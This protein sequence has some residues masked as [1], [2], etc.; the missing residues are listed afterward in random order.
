MISHQ[1]VSFNQ[2]LSPDNTEKFTLQ[3]S[4]T[5]QGPSLSVAPTK[6]KEFISYQ[7]WTKALE[8]FVSIYLMAHPKSITK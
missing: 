4:K 6:T 8:I 7:Q 1:Y 5:Q 2:L 3:F